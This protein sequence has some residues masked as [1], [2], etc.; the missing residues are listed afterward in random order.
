MG[1]KKQDNIVYGQAVR[2]TNAGKTSTE[3]GKD[4]YVLKAAERAKDRLR[5]RLLEINGG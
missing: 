5:S 2:L 4:P 3:K 1:E